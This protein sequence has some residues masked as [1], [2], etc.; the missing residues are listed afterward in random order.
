MQMTT[1][2]GWG[3][4][5][6]ANWPWIFV[7][8]KID[9]FISMI[10][11]NGIM[12][13]Y[14]HMNNIDRVFLLLSDRAYFHINGALSSFHDCDS[15][16]RVGGASDDSRHCVLCNHVHLYTHTHFHKSILSFLA[17]WKLRIC[18]L[19]KCIRN[20]ILILRIRQLLHSIEY[21]YNLTSG[22]VISFD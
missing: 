19:M 4:T 21:P 11:G 3:R 13:T 1:D 16:G 14:I 7:W 5:V 9:V 18:L 10:N 15:D 17:G 8:D 6:S 2:V 20:C 12:H 22:N